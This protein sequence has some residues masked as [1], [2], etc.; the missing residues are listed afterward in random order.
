MVISIPLHVGDDSEANTLA[1]QRVP[2]LRGL[3]QTEDIWS[4]YRAHLKA[5]L[6]SKVANPADVDDLLQD[7][8]IKTHNNIQQLATDTSIKSWLFQIAQR[9]II[10][11]YRKQGRINRIDA[12]N[13]W[14]GDD[15]EPDIK[16]ELSQCIAPL[17]S[18][19]PDDA[20]DLLKAIDL[21]DMS[22]KDY[23]QSIGV[24][25]STLKSRVQ[26]ARSLLK[27]QFEHCCDFHLDS[28]GNLIEFDQKQTGCKKC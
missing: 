5:F 15:H 8:F 26:K 17:L 6:H 9:T 12:E 23:A 7:I 16:A 18:G 10:D 28:H 25:Y 14:Y 21:N 3:M 2:P 19:I 22:Q 27:S 24:S 20:A 1:M 11:F 13:L 4:L